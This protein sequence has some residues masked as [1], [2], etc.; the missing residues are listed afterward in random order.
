MKSVKESVSA[1]KMVMKRSVKWREEIS[2]A[3]IGEENRKCRRN[4]ESGAGAL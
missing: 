2:K 3:K 4:G 1:K